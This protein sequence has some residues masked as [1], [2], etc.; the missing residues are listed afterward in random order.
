MS[1]VNNLGFGCVSLTLLPFEQA[2]LRLLDTAYNEGITHFDTA[3]LYGNGYS[4]KI[5]GKFLK[6]KRNKVTVTTKFGLPPK[7]AKAI[8]VWLALPLN[9][10]QKKIKDSE[11]KTFSFGEP[12]IV[13]YRKIDIL[14]V[15]QSFEKSIKSLQT[16]CIDYFLL[17]EALPAFLTDEAMHYLSTLKKNGDIGKI[18]IATSYVSIQQLQPSQLQ[19][20][21]ILQY[22]NGLAYQS[23]KLVE[24]YTHQTHFYHSVFKAAKGIR[25]NIFDTNNIAGILLVKAIKNNPS[26]KVLFGTSKIENLQRNL[27]ALNSCSKMSITE[28]NNSLEDALH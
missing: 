16:G 4:E 3:P 14:E 22:E 9:Y 7:G 15:R 19:L 18:G 20:W 27:L 23:D 1:L 24:V 6:S 8:P 17:H 12:A 13:H 2:A 5:V 10:L 25:L 21:D 11:K 28:I 26:G